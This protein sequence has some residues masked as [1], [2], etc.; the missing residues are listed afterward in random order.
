M[1]RKGLEDVYMDFIGLICRYLGRKMKCFDRNFKRYFVEIILQRVEV[2]SKF[3]TKKLQILF[4]KEMKF[5][6]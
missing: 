3:W 4:I 1:P 2:S 6:Q 5:S